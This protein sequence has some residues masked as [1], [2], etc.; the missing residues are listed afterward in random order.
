MLRQLNSNVMPIEWQLN[1]NWLSM[2]E[3]LT[4][5]WV[6]IDCQWNVN[7][8]TI[9]CQL[10]DNWLPSD[11]QLESHFVGPCL[12]STEFISR[13]A[14]RSFPFIKGNDWGADP[15]MNSFNKRI[16]P[17]DSQLA[18]GVSFD[19]LNINWL[20]WFPSINNRANW[21]PISQWSL[22]WPILCQLN[23]SSANP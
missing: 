12:Y 18:K 10:T 21:L 1:T 22:I 8:L 5:M 9:E 3:Q 20:R 17:I 7:S 13:Q 19:Q 2:E 16:M 11:S 6:S 4:T 14:P 23:Q 15:E